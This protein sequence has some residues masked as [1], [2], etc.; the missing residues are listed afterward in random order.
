[1]R[2]LSNDGQPG[3]ARPSARHWIVAFLL[4]VAI[5]IAAWFLTRPSIRRIYAHVALSGGEVVFLERHNGTGKHW[6]TLADREGPRLTHALGDRIV[7]FSGSRAAGATADATTLYLVEAQHSLGD[8]FDEAGDVAVAAYDRQTG[9]VRWKTSL[10]TGTTRLKT[11]TMRFI[12]V[13]NT[14]VTVSLMALDDDRAQR[15]WLFGLDAASGEL[16]WQSRLDLPGDFSN[17]RII[18][19]DAVLGVESQLDD[20]EQSLR[21]SAAPPA[22]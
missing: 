18:H 17:H 2:T 19:G 22:R 1:M 6:W 21:S 7:M 8:D 4:V 13:A 16:V 5:G 12:H 15:P 3:L 11:P 20:D 14:R 9:D 10:G